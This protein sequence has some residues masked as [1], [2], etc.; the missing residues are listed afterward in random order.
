[1]PTQWNDRLIECAYGSGL[2]AHSDRLI[3]AGATLSAQEHRQLGEITATLTRLVVTV[4]EREFAANLHDFGARLGKP[5]A[6]M[7]L[8][9]ALSDGGLDASIFARADIVRSADGFKLIELNLGSQIGGLYYASLPVLAGYRQ[10]YDALGA[11]ARRIAARG[12][13]HAMVFLDTREGTAWMPPYCTAMSNALQALTGCQ[14][15]LKACAALRFDGEQLLADGQ[16]VRALYSWM[17]DADLVAEGDRLAPVLEAVRHGAVR[18]VMSPLAPVF[19]DKGVFALLWELLHEGR[20]S[21][22]EA[23]FVARYVPF[24]ATLS[25]HNLD[26]FIADRQGLVLKPCDGYGGHGVR[27]GA[28]MSAPAWTQALRTLIEQG[29]AHGYIVQAL[30]RPVVERI[31]VGTRD[32]PPVQEQSHVVWGS[33]V[34]DGEYIGSYARSKPVAASLVINQGN[35]AAVGPVCA[36]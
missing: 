3:L 23:S 7:A 15:P 10:P 5:P 8:L 22:Q 25:K 14:V 18:L 32:Q 19:A 9:E 31:S 11:W 36:Q 33:F 16:P 29:A 21:A 6:T 1:M 4:F 35:G 28:E 24:T 34:L 26:D 2:Y 13:A 30:A 20:L 12:D 17:S 27:V